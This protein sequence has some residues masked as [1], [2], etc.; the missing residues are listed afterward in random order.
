MGIRVESEQVR[1]LPTQGSGRI[2]SLSTQGSGRIFFSLLPS[3]FAHSLAL[4]SSNGSELRTLRGLEEAE[5]WTVVL[6]T[7]GTLLTGTLGATCVLRRVACIK[8]RRTEIA[9]PLQ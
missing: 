5:R 1:A 3:S 7:A 9:A 2:F 8:S 6:A 4:A